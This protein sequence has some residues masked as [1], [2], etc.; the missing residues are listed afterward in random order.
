MR[1]DTSKL[2]DLDAL[3]AN[4]ESKQLKETLKESAMAG[5]VPP[6]VAARIDLVN[7]FN[8]TTH[9]VDRMTSDEALEEYN[10]R[11]SLKESIDI[12]SILMEWSYRCDKGYPDFNNKHD[13]IKLQEI[14]DE[15][16]VASPFKRITEAPESSDSKVSAFP[17]TLVAKLKKAGK[18]EKFKQYLN[19]F[20]GGDAI[21]KVSQGVARICT[22][23]SDED[24]LVSLFKS[25]KKLDSILKIDL[26][27][28][29]YNK[30]Y[31]VRP[32]GTGPGEILI[33]WYVEDAM[34]QGGNVS[35]D[36]DYKGQHWEVKSLISASGGNTPAAIDPAKYGGIKFIFISS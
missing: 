33:S 36:I 31:N 1:K 9:E 12:D 19:L 34:F 22:N 30:L 16:G 8:F 20:P 11:S 23:K 24:A 2:I 5:N 6:E 32:S 14:L 15:M 10:K 18:L 3:F 21:E 35:Y 26:Q 17:A 27:T 29:I 25:T 13:M 7:K 28:G 4:A